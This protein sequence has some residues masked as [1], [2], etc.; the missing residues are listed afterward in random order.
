MGAE[1]RSNENIIRDRRSIG[2]SKAFRDTLGITLFNSYDLDF[3]FG[4]FFNVIRV[5]F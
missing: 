1:E 5:S 4:Y 3:T 2:K